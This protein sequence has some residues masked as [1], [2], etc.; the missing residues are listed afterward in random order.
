MDFVNKLV[1]IQKSVGIEKPKV[2]RYGGLNKKELNG[3]K[4]QQIEEYEVNSCT[5]YIEPVEYGSKIY[6][7]AV[8]L[9][10]EFLS[11]YKPL[12]I[13]KNSCAYFGVDYES[14]KRGTR[15]LIGYNRKIPIVIEPTNHM[16]FFPT[17]SPDSPECIWFS[18]EHIENCHRVAAQ[19]TLIIF[20]NKQ[21][22]VFPVSYSTIQT[23]MLR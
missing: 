18:H 21:S 20:R 12:D 3:L 14:R 9:E 1:T 15:N 11:P 19:Q 22:R 7:H 17:A 2:V 23:Q 4:H 16:F 6:S 13:I 8:E 5:M 10:D